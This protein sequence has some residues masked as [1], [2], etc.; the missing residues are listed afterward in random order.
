VDALTG[1][2]ESKFPFDYFGRT[3]NQKAHLAYACTIESSVAL[4][5]RQRL[6]VGVFSQSLCKVVFSYRARPHDLKDD[7]DN[8]LDQEVNVIKAC[9]GSYAGIQAGLEIKYERST[10][11]LTESNEYIIIEI[12]FSVYHTI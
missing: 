11:R 5:E 3:T 1:F 12:E 6:P 2:H 10:R 4:P 7:Y 8:A 9:L